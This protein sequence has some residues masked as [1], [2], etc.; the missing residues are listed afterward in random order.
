M[1]KFGKIDI[2]VNWAAG[3]FLAPFDK[4]SSNGFKTVL[5]IDTLGTFNVSKVVY[6][7]SMEK[8]GGNIVNISATL[9]YNS[10]SMMTHA[11]AAKAGVDAITRNLAV[12][13]VNKN[14]YFILI[15]FKLR[16]LKI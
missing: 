16:D 11:C 13:L 14:Q 9:H 7:K 6:E 5:E 4:L 15:I 1:E 10:S 2:L 12:E 3:N 8:N